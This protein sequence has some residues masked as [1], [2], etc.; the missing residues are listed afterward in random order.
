M[1]RAQVRGSSLEARGWGEP[2]SGSGDEGGSGGGGGSGGRGG[3]GDGG[4]DDAFNRGEPPCL[5]DFS[6]AR[7]LERV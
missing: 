2:A 3:S 5:N 7:G 4:K 1:G 6:P